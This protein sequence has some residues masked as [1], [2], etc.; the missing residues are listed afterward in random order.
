MELRSTLPPSGGAASALNELKRRLDDR[1]LRNGLLAESARPDAFLADG[2]DGE[3]A[4][5]GS[6]A[7][8]EGISV[9]WSGSSLQSSATQTAVGVGPIIGNAVRYT[10]TRYLKRR[11]LFSFV[12]QMANDTRVVYLAD[13]EKDAPSSRDAST[14]PSASQDT[15]NASGSASNPLK[16]QR[17]L[18][19]MFVAPKN[20]QSAKSG[21]RETKKAKLD[22]SNAASAG[23]TKAKVPV[24]GSSGLQRLNFI[25]FSLSEFIESIPEDRRHLLKLECEC[26]GKSW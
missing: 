9:C 21:Q 26:M 24:T 10:K 4:E 22:V 1:T 14:T 16:R 6:L 11:V 8:L 20:S 12:H 3:E 19:D 18:V 17:T 13:V 7:E 23:A 15:S 25:P 2:G 5:R